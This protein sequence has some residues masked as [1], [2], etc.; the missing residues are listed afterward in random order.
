[1]KQA[2][3]T[4]LAIIVDN[5]AAGFSAHAAGFTVNRPTA[6]AFAVPAVFGSLAAARLT[7]RLKDS[8]IRVSFAALV[9]IVAAWV[10][11]STAGNLMPT[12]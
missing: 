4:S 3:G 9:F 2:V 7:R 11:V 12:A 1:M 5:S 8:H 6:L 10:T